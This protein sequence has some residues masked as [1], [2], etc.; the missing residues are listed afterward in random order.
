MLFSVFS[1]TIHLVPFYVPVII[2]KDL[3]VQ[4]WRAFDH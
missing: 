2:R 1:G 3:R 4:Q